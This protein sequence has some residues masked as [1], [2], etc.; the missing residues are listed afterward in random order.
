[1]SSDASVR[2]VVDTNVLL[3]G[4]LWR[5]APHALLGHVRNGSVSLICSPA[6]L[7][8]LLD[9]LG[10]PKFQVVLARASVEAHQLYAELRQ[11]SEIME[12]PPLPSP[13][14]RDPDDDAVLALAVA[15]QADVI[16]SGDAD[17]LA[18]GSYVRIPIVDVS[19]AL[20]RILAA[21][22]P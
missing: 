7:G 14:S 4:L 10:R 11:L 17:P 21:P 13:V 15:A 12:P 20:A 16:V 2:A 8:E 6:L 5:G 18:L 22:S 1:M 3:S 9:V 19:A